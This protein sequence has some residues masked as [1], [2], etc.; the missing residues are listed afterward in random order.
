[1]RREQRNETILHIVIRLPE[2]RQA[3]A[4]TQQQ[5][6]QQQAPDSNDGGPVQL[7][8]RRGRRPFRL[9]VSDCEDW[10]DREAHR[11]WNIEEENVSKIPGAYSKDVSV[12]NGT[13]VHVA[14]SKIPSPGT[15]RAGLIMGLGSLR[16]G[17][18]RMAQRRCIVSPRDDG[19]QSCISVGYSEASVTVSDGA[20]A[21]RIVDVEFGDLTSIDTWRR[22]L[23]VPPRTGGVSDNRVEAAAVGVVQCP[24]V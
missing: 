24:S 12:V 21:I 3:T 9:D 4:T 10:C 2:T 13:V 17:S 16:T 6:Q 14:I 23:G 18:L 7:Q 8:C 1:M 11:R 15:W 5:Q 22:L 20:T 19:S